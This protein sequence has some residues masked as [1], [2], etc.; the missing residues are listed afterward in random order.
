MKIVFIDTLYAPVLDKLGHFS[1]KELNKSAKTLLDELAEQDFA[2]GPKYVSEIKANQEDAKFVVA[3]SM[4]AQRAWAKENNVNVSRSSA[5]LWKRWQLISRVPII[6][7]YI[8][9]KSELVKILMAQIQTESPDVVYN[10]NLNL[11]NKKL[12][13]RLRAENIKIV[14]QIA[15]PLPP[16]KFITRYHHIFSA[17]PGQVKTFQ[18]LGISASWLALAFDSNKVKTFSESGWPKRFRDVSFVGTF[19]RHQKNTAPLMIS[20]AKLNPTLEIFSFAKR[21][22]MEKLGL[23]ENF[24]GAAW[25][26]TMYQVFAES[27]VV[28]NRHGKVAD[29]FAVNFRLFEATG[30]GALVLTESA[31]NLNDLFVE[32]EEIITYKNNEDAAQKIKNILENFRDYAD[33]AKAGQQRTLSTHN[34]SARAKEILV[35]LIEIQSRS[36]LV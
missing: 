16:K 32:G 31:P 17:H 3:N 14:G 4:A 11:L 1:E 29:G 23:G 8:H 12:I 25:G 5:F 27:K 33:I 22:M 26:K 6:G 28:V 19:G 9:T 2:S 21:R 24:K 7:L 18:K 20:V 36:D 15:S 34:Y 13:N 30:M 35:K 10:L